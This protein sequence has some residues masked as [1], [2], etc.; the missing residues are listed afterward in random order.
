[1]PVFDTRPVALHG[2]NE[3][4]LSAKT[5]SKLRIPDE[6]T[7]EW[8]ILPPVDPLPGYTEVMKNVYEYPENTGA[9]MK[10][11]ALVNHQVA[12]VSAK[13]YEIEGPRVLDR[14]EGLPPIQYNRQWD[15]S[16]YR[17]EY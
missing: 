9:I 6:Q 1:M 10:P 12:R 5:A 7:E 8:C 17:Y 13:T 15:Q 2:K 11:P 16:Y 4:G 3:F 14:L